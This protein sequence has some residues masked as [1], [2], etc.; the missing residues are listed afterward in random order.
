MTAVPPSSPQARPGKPPRASW[1][2]MTEMVLP[3]HTNAVG[4]AFGGVV[5]SW[6]DIAA[7]TAALRHA[8]LSVV[9]A[10]IDAMHF[11]APVRLG[12]I[13]TLKASVNFTARTSMEVGVRVAAENPITGER[14]HTASGYLTFVAVD[15]SGN[16]VPIPP[17]LPETAEEKARFTRGA[18]RRRLRL[19]SRASLLRTTPSPGNG[20]V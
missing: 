17:L 4:T 10:S 12:W 2:E 15:S 1:V 8:N 3:Q 5:M 16:A 6:V 7:A 9:T 19:E 20:S 18:E 11:L 14:H 13:V